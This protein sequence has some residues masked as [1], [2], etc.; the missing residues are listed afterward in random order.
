MSVL[1]RAATPGDAEAAAS[2]H[3]RSQQVAYAPFGY[4]SPLS[5]EERAVRNAAMVR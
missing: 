2:T 3:I 5:V 4:L 1:I